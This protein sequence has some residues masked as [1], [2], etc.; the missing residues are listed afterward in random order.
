MGNLKMS[1]SITNFSSITRNGFIRLA[2]HAKEVYGTVIRAGLNKRTVTV[3][4]S[5]YSWNNKVGIWL[6][7]SRNVHAHDPESFCVT[8]DKVILLQCRKLSNIKSHH[9]HEIIKPAAR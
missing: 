8:G 1:T 5:G 2:P 7:N 6:N 3:R 4:V 9:V